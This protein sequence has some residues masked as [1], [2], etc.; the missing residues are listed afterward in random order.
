MIEN[1]NKT[2]NSDHGRQRKSHHSYSFSPVEE[3][4]KVTVLMFILITSPCIVETKEVKKGMLY[5]IEHQKIKNRITSLYSFNIPMSK[6]TDHWTDILE[7]QLLC[8]KR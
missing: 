3:K 4:E 6:F 2:K 5:F 8:L 1:E 7:P